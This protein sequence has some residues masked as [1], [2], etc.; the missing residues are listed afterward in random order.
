MSA[1]RHIDMDQS[2]SLPRGS[3]RA[4]NRRLS[5]LARAVVDG[6]ETV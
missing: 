6:F 5:D 1:G 2:F 4:S 3:A